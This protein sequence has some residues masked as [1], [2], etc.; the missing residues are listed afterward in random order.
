LQFLFFSYFVLT[1]TS[2]IFSLGSFIIRWDAILFIAGFLAARKLLLLAYE[3][4]A[5]NFKISAFS[6]YLVLAAMVGSRLFYLLLY[7]PRA[8]FTKF[9][10]II[11]PFE[12]QPHFNIVGRNEFSL[13]GGIIGILLFV[14]FHRRALNQTYLQVLDRIW[15]PCAVAGIFMFIISFVDSDIVGQQTESSV[16]T[17]FLEPVKKGL[18]KVPCCIMR[19]PDGKNPL[20]RVTVSKDPAFAGARTSQPPLNFQLFFEPG[21][22]EQLVNEF[23]V[24]DVKKFLYDMSLYV[25]ETGTEPLRHKIDH[26]PDGTYVARVGTRGIARFPVQVF[27]AFVLLLISAMLFRTWRNS[28]RIAT[29]RSLALFMIPFW[30]VHLLFQ[31]IKIPDAN[32]LQLGIPVTYFLNV[33]FIGFGLTILMLS[34]RTVPPLD[35]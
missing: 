23:L 33:I 32:V 22:S 6:I 35:R 8:I 1:G 20:Q 2:E 27:E 13:Y 19:S 12:W 5:I 4:D 31:F 3:K 16:G 17:V 11:L 24:G 34:Y 10:T 26:Q 7:E 9:H 25:H 30:T 28:S 18:L 15:L 14:W 29:G 21:L